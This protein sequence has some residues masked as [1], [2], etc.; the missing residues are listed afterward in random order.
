MV[1]VVDLVIIVG[2]VPN[3]Q[4]NTRR[5]MLLGIGSLVAR[6][7]L[8]QSALIVVFRGTIDGPVST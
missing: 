6:R 1:T 3:D 2:L 4:K 7:V 8:A 5:S